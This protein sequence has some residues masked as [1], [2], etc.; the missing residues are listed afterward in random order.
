MFWKPSI[1]SG[2]DGGGIGGPVDGVGQDLELAG[3][4]HLPQPGHRAEA[5]HEAA[6]LAIPGVPGGVLAAAVHV[7]IDLKPPGLLSLPVADGREGDAHLGVPA[8]LVLE[9]LRLPHRVPVLVAVAVVVDIGVELHAQGVD[10]E[11][12][13]GGVVE[14][15]IDI[16]AHDVRV[17]HAVAAGEALGDVLGVVL[18]TGHGKIDRVVVV[19][20]LEHRLFRGRLPPVGIPHGEPAGGLR[21]VPEDLVQLAVDLDLVPVLDEDRR[22]WWGRRTCGRRPSGA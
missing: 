12:V 10:A 21:L 5:A 6:G 20:D 19:G 22:E 8:A 4:G 13:A 2:P 11:V 7:A 17:A 3:S 9:G 18:Q 15:G 1:S 14:V 16:D